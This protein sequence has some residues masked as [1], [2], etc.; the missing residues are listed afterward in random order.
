[1]RSLAD[2]ARTAAGAEAALDAAEEGRSRSAEQRDR[3]ES[4]LA[5]ARAALAA[6]AS[7]REALTKALAQGGGAALANVRADPG[8]ERA[9]AAALGDDLDAALGGD[10]PRRWAGSEPGDADP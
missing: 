6:A 9:L 4:A 5:A 7:E 1:E 8:Y 2:A 10:A 3:H